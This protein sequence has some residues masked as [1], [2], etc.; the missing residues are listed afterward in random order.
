MFYVNDDWKC[1][2]MLNEEWYVIEQNMI[3]DNLFLFINRFFMV[4]NV[5]YI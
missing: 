3:I 2:I 5:L 1:L 4:V